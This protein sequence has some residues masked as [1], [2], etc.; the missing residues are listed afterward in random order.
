MG[1]RLW[2]IGFL[3]G[4]IIQ[5]A[6]PVTF[7]PRPLQTPL[8]AQF[9]RQAQ[10]LILKILTVFLRLK[11]SPSLNLNKN[12]HFA[13]VSPHIFRVRRSAFKVVDAYGMLTLPNHEP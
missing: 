3:T 6:L 2:G 5:Y 8:F 12:Q 4:G 7:A 1:Y 10:I 11:F 13:K 9:L